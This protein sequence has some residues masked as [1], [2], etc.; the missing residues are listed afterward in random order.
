MSMALP[1]YTLTKRSQFVALRDAEQKYVTPS[2]V[3]QYLH[4]A[5]LPQHARYSQPMPSFFFA[6]GYTVTKKCG[7]AVIRNRMKR[8][9]R[10]VVR[11]VMKEYGVQHFPQGCICVVIARHSLNEYNHPTLLH[12]VRRAMKHIAYQFAHQG[13]HH[14]VAC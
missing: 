10:A 7:N 5:S 14:V 9:L 8:R 3:I 12:H 13:Q 4:P 2:C 1:F 6:V 11:E